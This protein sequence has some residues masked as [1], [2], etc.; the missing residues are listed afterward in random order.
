M[1]A[2]Q[3]LPP[4]PAPPY[5]LHRHSASAEGFWIQSFRKEEE[6]EEED[7]LDFHFNVYFFSCLEVSLW[8][9]FKSTYSLNVLFVVKQTTH[10]MKMHKN[11]Y[12]V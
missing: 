4:H 10:Y 8:F 3:Q 7:L 6:K 12:V 5:P 11:V 9:F 1:E 2:S